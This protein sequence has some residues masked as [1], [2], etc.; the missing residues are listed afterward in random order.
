M[1]SYIANGRSP[2][3]RQTLNE[4]SA[5]SVIAISAITEGELLYGLA[6][7]PEAVQLHRATEVV[8]AKVEILPWDSNA[9]VAY[10]TLRLR[11][12]ARGKSLSANDLLIAAHAIATDATL[13]TRDGAF[14]QIDALR[15]LV[16]WATDL[17]GPMEV[18]RPCILEV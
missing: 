3:A 14:S 10:A 8:L 4:L 16:N 5:H 2:L 9:A 17:E 7:R 15:P 1:V 18:R 13:V 6:R 11:M 12:S